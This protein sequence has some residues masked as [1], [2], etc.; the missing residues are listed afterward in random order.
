VVGALLRLWRLPTQVLVDDE[1]HAIRATFDLSFRDILTT[2]SSADFCQPLTAF[3]RLSVESGLWLSEFLLR[4]PVVSIGILGVVVLPALL[5]EEVAPRTRVLFAWL[6]AISPNLVLYSRIVRSYGIVVVVL[7]AS[8][9]LFWRWQ[10]SKGSNRSGI[11]SGLGLGLAV[12]LHLGALPTVASLFGFQVVA[13][14]LSRRLPQ[15]RFLI[16][17]AAFG[18]ACLLF[19]VPA[20]SSLQELLGEKRMEQVIPRDITWPLLQLQTGTQTAVAAIAVLLG[21]VIGLGLCWQ[22]QMRFGWFLAALFFGHVLGLMLLSP[23]GLASP[24]IFNRYLV[25]VTPFALL[26]L[27]YALSRGESRALAGVALAMLFAAGPLSS[28]RFWSPS[29]MHS[30]DHMSFF[31][32][33]PA[34][35]STALSDEYAFVD[36]LPDGPVVEFPFRNMTLISRAP[37]VASRLHGR[38]VLVST[39][40][41]LFQRDRLKLRNTVVPAPARLLASEAVGL[42]LHKDP[43]AAEALVQETRWVPQFPVPEEEWNAIQTATRNKQDELVAEL[44][45]PH[46][47]GQFLAI[48]NLQEIRTER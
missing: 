13:Q 41:P 2:Y 23:W 24:Q 7:A 9:F 21:I 35:A 39:L 44:G 31:T 27:S 10:E 46:F 16:P 34:F 29:F 37:I 19:V 28:P 15:P 26:A 1:L 12:Y 43:R 20:S 40:D 5:P 14:I 6:L 38:R 22:K 32:E 36:Q 11:V 33:P 48:W 45:P 30:H 47:E 42:I 3:Y 25:F 4:L 18:T 17:G 8:A